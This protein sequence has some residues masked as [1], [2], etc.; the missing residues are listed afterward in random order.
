MGAIFV[1]TVIALGFTAAVAWWLWTLDR[2]DSHTPRMR[3]HD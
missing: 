1:L 3:G 2:R